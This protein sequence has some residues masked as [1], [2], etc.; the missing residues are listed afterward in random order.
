MKKV[1]GIF[2]VL[3]C[4]LLVG[5]DIGSKKKEEKKKDT[6]LS[7]SKQT[8]ETQSGITFTTE[9]IYTF[10]DDSPTNLAVKYSYDLSNYK[11]K[12]KYKII[13]FMKPQ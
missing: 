7:C 9:M 2:L 12:S 5:C 4:F 1:L 13:H 11:T 6:V 10:K 8:T 3:F